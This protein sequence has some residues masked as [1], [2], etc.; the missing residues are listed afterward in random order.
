MSLHD[1]N[2]SLH[3]AVHDLE[4]RLIARALGEARGSVTKAA[5]LLGV[6]HQ[7]LTNMLN[8]RHTKLQQKRTPVRKRLRSIIA[9]DKKE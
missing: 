8:T 3:G 5:R 6:S 1:R 9:K 2:F 7:L 4:T